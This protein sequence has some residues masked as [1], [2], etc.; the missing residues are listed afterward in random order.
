[1]VRAT[2]NLSSNLDEIRHEILQA[3]SGLETERA[4]SIL[5]D[6]MSRAHALSLEHNALCFR[7]P[8][9]D[10]LCVKIS[11]QVTARDFP[12]SW[13]RSDIEHSIASDV[14]VASEL[15]DTGGHTPLIGDFI[16]AGNSRPAVVLVT[17]IN[18][19][20]K[21]I[22]HPIL[23]R[24][25]INAKQIQVCPQ[26]AL[27]GKVEWLKSA[28]A[29]LAPE[30]V[31]LFNHPHD[32]AAVAACGSLSNSELYFV[33]HVDRWPCFGAFMKGVRHIDLSPFCSACCRKKAH[34]YENI[35]IP[36]PS[37]DHGCRNFDDWRPNENGIVTA[38]AGNEAKFQTDYIP[39][40]PTTIAALL[41]AGSRRHIHI[42]ALSD[43][44]L[45]K[46]KSELAEAGISEEKLIYVPR[47]PSVWRAMA[48]YRVDLYIG[49]FPVRGARTSVEVMGS[50]TPAVWHQLNV[51]TLFHDNH[52]KYPEALTWKSVPDLLGIVDKID[53]EWLKTQSRAARARYVSI[54]HPDV[55]RSLLRQSPISGLDVDSFA[56]DFEHPRLWS[57]DELMQ[58]VEN[59]RLK[60]SLD[61]ILRAQQMLSRKNEELQSR[62]DTIPASRS[63]RTAWPV[64]FLRSRIG[65]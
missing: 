49:S 48:G 35:F 2:M 59:Q 42:G 5:K 1:M 6:V 10:A 34:I 17:D 9:L 50:G 57:F 20:T 7:S 11:E 33:H 21:D 43:E 36:I 15:Y 65:R 63:W 14:Y 16:A 30:R 29:A 39:S 13:D 45:A 54:H 47:V 27:I 25:G 4:L 52:M 19:R 24:M 41:R 38:A 40:Y 58:A 51:D 53:G 32:S 26:E 28:F 55:V 62:L 12:S 44:Y 31:F 60:A 8:E 3:I 22:S 23:A 18:N 64:R 37:E 61:S 56:H 46:L